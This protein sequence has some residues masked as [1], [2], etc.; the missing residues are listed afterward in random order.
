MANCKKGIQD[1]DFSMSKVHR[2]MRGY[3]D[4]GNGMAEE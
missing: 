3:I 2:K 1:G 4:F